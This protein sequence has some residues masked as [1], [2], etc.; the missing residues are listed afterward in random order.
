MIGVDHQELRT[1]REQRLERGAP[2]PGQ[3]RRVDGDAIDRVQCIFGGAQ[4]LLDEIARNANAIGKSYRAADV[5][6]GFPD[7]LRQ[8]LFRVLGC[9]QPH[10]AAAHREQR[11]QE[12]DP[13]DHGANT[14][15]RP[16][17]RDLPVLK[18]AEAQP[19]DAGDHL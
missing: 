19:E 3:P 4:G 15:L 12:Y 13:S 18:F 7:R 11:Q 1:T 17:T 16:G 6:C 10:H 5:R 9:P 2:A 8:E 14:G